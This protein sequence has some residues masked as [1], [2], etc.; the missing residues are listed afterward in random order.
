MNCHDRFS[1]R[2]AI[3]TIAGGAA[4]AGLAARIAPLEALAATTQPAKMPTRPLG[5]TGHQVCLFSLGGQATIEQPNRGDEAAAI[6][7]RAIDLGVNYIDTAA[8]YGNGISETYIGQVMKT[9]RKEVFLA[10]KTHDR[11]YDG[12]MRLLERSLTNLQTDRL[13]LWQLHNITK[14]EDLEKIFAADGAIKALEKARDQK[15]TRF[16]GITGH[17]DPAL[18]KKGIQRY[19]FDS[20]LMSLNAADKHSFSFINELLPIAAEKKM[21]IVGMKVISRGKIFQPNGITTMQQA[22]RYVL[23]LPVSTVI[24]GISKLAELDEN[25]RIAAEFQ[26]CTKEEMAKL[27]ELTR[28]YYAAAN[29][30]RRKP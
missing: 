15:L 4:A 18:L 20:V 5:Q 23:T 2:K 13:D 1:R 7:N 27:E 22:M 14:E 30:F 16:L 25:V 6:V 8:A 19:P 24:V 9:R 11:S 10:S 12:S 21:A 3:R 17:F 26:S 29:W 28:P